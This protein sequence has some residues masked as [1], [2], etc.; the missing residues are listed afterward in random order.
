MVPF[1]LMQLS[2]LMLLLLLGKDP[3]ALARLT[4]EDL[5]FLFVN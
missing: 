5:R 3:G 1:V 4:P 2:I